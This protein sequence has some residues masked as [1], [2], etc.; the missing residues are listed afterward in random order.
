M[1]RLRVFVAYLLLPFSKSVLLILLSYVAGD[2]C[3][4]ISFLL[5]SSTSVRGYLS[6]EDQSSWSFGC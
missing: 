4:M 2:I 1:D 6:L 5:C 3:A